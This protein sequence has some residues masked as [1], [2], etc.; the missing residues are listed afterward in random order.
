MLDFGQP[1]QRALHHLT[2]AEAQGYLQAGQ[3]AAGS[4]G[5]KIRAA[6]EFVAGGGQQAIITQLDQAVAALAGTTGTIIER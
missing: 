1:T 6:V 3:F 2:V 4:M 5:P